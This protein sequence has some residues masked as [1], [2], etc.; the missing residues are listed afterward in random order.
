MTEF[1]PFGTEALAAS[2]T[3]ASL[4]GAVKL[5]DKARRFADNC[6]PRAAFDGSAFH[7]SAPKHDGLV[8]VIES[9][10]LIG[11]IGAALSAATQSDVK[12]IVMHGEPI[13][14]TPRELN[15]AMLGMSRLLL[16][17]LPAG[18]EGRQPVRGAPM[19]GSWIPVEQ[20]QPPRGERL[21]VL[22]GSDG[23]K[24]CN[25]HHPGFGSDRW[26]EISEIAGVSSNFSCDFISTGRVTHWMPLP[27]TELG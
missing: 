20:R 9:I 5:S 25:P 7:V 2:M 8:S 21:L 10:S 11:E 23:F 27:P 12:L 6:A 18:V 22:R 17:P 13:S 1:K 19:P 14:L 3:F 24:V 4:V 15:A 26:V 16:Q